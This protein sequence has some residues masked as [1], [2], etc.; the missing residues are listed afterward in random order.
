MSVGHAADL[1]LMAVGVAT[2]GGCLF[3]KELPAAAQEV[4]DVLASAAATLTAE[5]VHPLPPPPP[6][7]LSA[8]S[9]SRL[10]IGIF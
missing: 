10:S 2:V 4:A 8:L 5:K 6:G 9:L 3:G 1:V 7:A